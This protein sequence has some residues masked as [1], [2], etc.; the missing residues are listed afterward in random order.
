MYSYNYNYIDFPGWNDSAEGMKVLNG[1]SENLAVISPFQEKYCEKDGRDL[2]IRFIFPEKEDDPDRKYPL[3]I[4]VRGSGWDDQNLEGIMGTFA[5]IIH[6]GF[7]IAIVEYRSYNYARYPAMVLD[8]K[9]AARYILKNAV[10]YPI[11]SNN[12]FISGDS[13]GGHTAVMGYLTWNTSLLDDPSESDPLPEIRGLLDFYGVTDIYDLANRET[14]LPQQTNALLLE[15]LFNSEEEYHTADFHS[16]LKVRKQLEPAIIIHGN[17]DRLVPLSHST[18]FYK[19]LRGRGT[20]CELYMVDKADHG[21]SFFWCDPVY[22]VIISFL[23]N[24]VRKEKS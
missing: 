14:G 21:G 9:T 5:P 17:K 2:H 7:A 22:D 23:K 8:F 19:G 3:M 24:N 13:S 1:D 12:I 16:Y 11:D 6:A 15:A 20:E 4:H 10:G 18:D